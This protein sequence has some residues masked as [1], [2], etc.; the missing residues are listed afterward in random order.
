[1]FSANK[2]PKSWG[3]YPQIAPNRV[4]PIF[5]RDE[6]PNLAELELSILPHGYGRSYGDSCLNEDG[7]L[8]DMSH[9]TRFLSFDVEK[10]LLRCEAGVS[11]ADILELIVPHGWFLSVTPGTKFVSIGGAI[12]N[13][14]HGKN[15]H[16]AGTFG[17]HITCFELL[18]SDGRRLLCS[19]EENADLFQATIGGLG[20]T[21]V[22]LWAEI[23]LRP[24][25]SPLIDM[26]RI[27]FASLTEFI[28]IAAASEQDFEYTVAW[29]DCLASG[30]QLG[31]GFF[32][33]G[34]H[35]EHEAS[36]TIKKKRSR[37]IP[38]DF[39]SWILNIQTIRAL[40]T[41]YFHA[42]REKSVRKIGPYDPF[43]YPLD[44]IHQWN[45]V[46]GKRGFFQYQCI[47]P[48]DSGYE[49]MKEL[50]ERVSRSGQGSFPSVLKT[51]GD[52]S[53]PG[54]LS[55]P[56]PGLELALDFA[57]QGKKTLELLEDLDRV[58]C[59]SSGVVYPAKDARMSS[60]S[61]EVY[62]PH[63]REFAEYID[64]K[65]SS[66]FWRRVTATV[67]DSRC[68]GTAGAT[69]KGDTVN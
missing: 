8:L 68:G 40:N 1:M 10:G 36:I 9:L 29:V 27:R 56:R 39:P 14:V 3:C 67:G 61:F 13:D 31:R 66:S 45:R 4:L 54:M 2:M 48:H 12:A 5:W 55:F 15:H 17:C 42:Q 34:N 50:L 18:R 35:A 32:T 24:I 11:L 43:F 20:L 57:N 25:R 30:K 44:A 58:V 63:W 23:R 6:L 28:D 69:P 52:V 64:P 60:E 49:V 33:R 59:Q 7:I 21:G 65:F 51:F 46:Y 26:E 41:A 37:T 53:S 47:V 19:P 16:R 62:F 22:I 38:V